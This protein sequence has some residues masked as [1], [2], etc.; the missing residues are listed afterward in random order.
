MPPKHP[1]HLPLP[2]PAVG[3]QWQCP[4]CGTGWHVTDLGWISGA[5]W[6]R[7]SWTRPYVD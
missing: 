5:H 4:D 2:V 3:T 7:T 1:C 6:E